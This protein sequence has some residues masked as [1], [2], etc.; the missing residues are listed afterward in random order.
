MRGIIVGFYEG[1]HGFCK[2]L[3]DPA[4]RNSAIGST[5]FFH[6]DNSPNMPDVILSWRDVVGMIVDFE[7]V[8][9]DDYR[10]KAVNLTPVG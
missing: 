5:I 9:I 8:A 3:A 1:G 6:L 2:A 7:L 10:E 4:D